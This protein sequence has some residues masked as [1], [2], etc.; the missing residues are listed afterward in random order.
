MP[1]NQNSFK[2]CFIFLHPLGVAEGKLCPRN[3]SPEVSSSYFRHSA[4]S[5]VGWAGKQRGKP[6]GTRMLG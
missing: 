2:K 4:P 6:E 1:G 5:K 3:L